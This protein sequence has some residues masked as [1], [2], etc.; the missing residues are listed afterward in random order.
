MSRANRQEAGVGGILNIDKAE[1]MT[2]HD[3]V[4]VMRRIS[5]IRRIGHTGTLDPL[6]TGV[7]L[8]CVGR[9]TR[10]SEYLLGQDKRYEAAVRL[11]QET[12]TYD[13]EG[14]IVAEKPVEVDRQTIASALSHF[15]GPIS[16]VPPMYSAV[17]KDGQPLY[18]LARK[19]VEVDRPSRQVTIYHLDLL[20]WQ[21]PYL[22]LDITCSSGTYI[23]SLAHDLGQLLGCG[24]HITALRRTA[25]A[26]FTVLEAVS[27]DTLTAETWSEH[28]LPAD[29]AVAHLPAV[30]F[31]VEDAA[32]LQLGRQI[33][34][35][36]NVDPATM[37][38]L[39]R[40]YNET[41]IFIG[42]IASGPGYWQ[43]RKILVP[44]DLKNEDNS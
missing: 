24:G 18:K 2:S 17:K 26:N 7:L 21:P 43:P 32:A 5:G 11:G 16:Q 28:L 8:L 42:I 12:T 37:P 38:E 15:R 3:V 41:G 20:D 4:A 29:S 23:R 25:V 39:A 30:K 35:E 19:G 9:A 1:G 22:H 34:F 13:A 44:F 14:D 31:S 27:L 36:G 33:S 10:L 40:A 6:A